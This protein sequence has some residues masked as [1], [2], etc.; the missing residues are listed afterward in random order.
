MSQVSMS[1]CLYAHACTNQID[2]VCTYMYVCVGQCTCVCM[3]VC[4]YV[5][6]YVCTR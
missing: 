5:C 4:R 2:V 3:Y 6:V 1:M